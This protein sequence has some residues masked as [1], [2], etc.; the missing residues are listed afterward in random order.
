MASLLGAHVRALLHARG[1]KAFA[2]LILPPWAVVSGGH[3]VPALPSLS[4]S[5]SPLACNCSGRSD[6][7]VFDRELYRS[8]GHGGRCLR[9]R[10]NTAGPRCERCRPNHYRWEPRAACQ[11]C[12]CDAAGSLHMQCDSSGACAC[13]ATVTGWKC[14]R[15]RDGFHSLGRGGCR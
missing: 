2:P 3:R 10:D 11:P 15:C 7:C 12:H 8:T 9:C 14:E 5:A 4:P 1:C 13:K 6:E